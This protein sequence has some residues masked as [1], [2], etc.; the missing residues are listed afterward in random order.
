MAQE[1]PVIGQ[2]YRRVDEAQAFQVVAVD[3]L[4]GTVEVQYF[5]GTVDELRLAQFVGQD[6]ERCE[7]SPDWTGAYDGV[8]RDDQGATEADMAPEDW[9]EPY[10]GAEG[11]RREPAPE[12]EPP[13]DPVLLSREMLENAPASEALYARPTGHERAPRRRK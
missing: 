12:E 2:W 9:N 4:E 13:P 6:I 7:A 1:F 3:E 5:D 8:A 11:A 10:R